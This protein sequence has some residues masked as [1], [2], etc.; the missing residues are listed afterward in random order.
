MTSPIEID[1]APAPV[2]IGTGQLGPETDLILLPVTG[3]AGPPG[4]AGSGYTHTQGSPSASWSITH[5]LGYY[6][7]VAVSVGG[8]QCLA[9]VIHSSI[10]QVAIVFASAQSGTARLV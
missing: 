5:N 9:D 4:S 10:N 2:R 1:V 6:P 3:P 8:Q 7:N